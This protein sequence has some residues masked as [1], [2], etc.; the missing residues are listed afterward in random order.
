LILRETRLTWDER[1]VAYRKWK[2][3]LQATVSAASP[4]KL[5]SNGTH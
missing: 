1:K 3:Q 5:A 2:V 4:L